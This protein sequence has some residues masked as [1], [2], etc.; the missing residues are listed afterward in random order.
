MT[1]EVDRCRLSVNVNFNNRTIAKCALFKVK[2]FQTKNLCFVVELEV[3]V[4]LHSKIRV[5]MTERCDE[6]VY[7]TRLMHL[8]STHIILQ[9]IY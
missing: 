7:P 2:N 5:L 3:Y 9:D 1:T 4:R 6:I 8:H